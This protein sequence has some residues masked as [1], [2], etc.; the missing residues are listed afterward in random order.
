MRKQTVVSARLDADTIALVDGIVAAQGRS[1]A[2]F[3]A[4]AVRE[5]ARREAEFLTFVQEGIDAVASG[6]WISHE[7]M[8]Q[9]IAD[10]RAGIEA[11]KHAG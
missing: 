8:K 11:A 10:R 2:W 5:H 1:R 7:E 6:D 9:W 3:V 4:Q